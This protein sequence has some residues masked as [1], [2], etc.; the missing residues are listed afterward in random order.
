M[1]FE[2]LFQW[3]CTA[4]D[5]VVFDESQ[6]EKQKLYDLLDFVYLEKELIS[7]KERQ[8]FVS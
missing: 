4:R 7:L 1:V 6:V 8:V 3:F 5:N 2:N